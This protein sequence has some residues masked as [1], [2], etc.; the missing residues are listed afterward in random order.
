ML[1]SVE[2]LQLKAVRHFRELPAQGFGG[3]K[4]DALMPADIGIR[5]A[6]DQQSMRCILEDR[7]VVLPFRV[8]ATRL[9][10]PILTNNGVIDDFRHHRCPLGVPSGS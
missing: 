5:T 9:W 7:L 4:L 6:L 10:M 3:V 2:E 1:G 8:P